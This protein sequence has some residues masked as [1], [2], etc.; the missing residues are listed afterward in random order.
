MK[1]VLFLGSANYYRSRFAEHL[2]NDL[3]RRSDLPWRAISRGLL[4]GKWGDAG[5]MSSSA[6]EAL[7]S[8]GVDVDRD[9]RPAKPL[10]PRDLVNSSLVVAMKECEHRPLM[11]EQFP[12]WAELVNY[13]NI[14]DVDRAEPHEALSTLEDE[15]RDLAARLEETGEIAGGF[16]AA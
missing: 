8:R 2:F 1:E 14:D 12:E 4:V 11:S 5:P 6:V 16:V 7:K 13:W 15:I 10:S 9:Q 3:A